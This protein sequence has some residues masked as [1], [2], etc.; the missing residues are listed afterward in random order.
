M[1]WALDKDETATRLG[2]AL[3]L[4]WWLRGYHSEGR[5]WVE[6]LL[7]RDLSPDLRPRATVVAAFMAYT[8][9]DFEACEGYSAAALQLSRKV[10]DT[11]CTAYARFMLGPSAMHRGDFEAAMSCFE[12][13]LMLFHGPARRTWCR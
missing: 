6:L 13:A 11:L 8:Q 3:W 7:K 10:G 5:R 9:G 12:E 4:F 1:A 2:W